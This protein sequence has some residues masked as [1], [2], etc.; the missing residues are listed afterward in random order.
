MI[1]LKELL[2]DNQKDAY[3]IYIRNYRG[4]LHMPGHKSSFV[5]KHLGDG[6]SIVQIDEQKK[7]FAA[8]GGRGFSGGKIVYDSGQ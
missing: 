5:I 4:C 6:Q 7:V 8:A 1:H 3:R 2:A